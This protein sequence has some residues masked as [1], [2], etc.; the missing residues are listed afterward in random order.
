VRRSSRSSNALDADALI[1]QL[2]AHADNE[3]LGGTVR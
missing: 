3:E 2:G 1:N